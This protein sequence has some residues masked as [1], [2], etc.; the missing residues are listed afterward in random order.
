[1]LRINEPERSWFHSFV[2]VMH[3][4]MS[5]FCRN[6]ERVIITLVIDHRKGEVDQFFATSNVSEIGTCCA[7]VGCG[8]AMRRKLAILHPDV[9][10]ED[11]E[12]EKA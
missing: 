10:D 11:N 7:L 8:Y 2:D 5:A 4:L 1:M 6:D 9:F 3:V 12:K